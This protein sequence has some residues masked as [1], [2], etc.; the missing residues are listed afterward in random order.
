MAATEFGRDAGAG[1]PGPNRYHTPIPRYHTPI[2][3]SPQQSERYAYF[4]DADE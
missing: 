3:E 4:G 1:G 2:S